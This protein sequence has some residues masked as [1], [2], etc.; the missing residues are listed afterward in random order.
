MN[1]KKLRPTQPPE[2]EQSAE[3][4]AWYSGNFNQ[5]DNTQEVMRLINE[6]SAQNGREPL[7]WEETLKIF[8]DDI[9]SRNL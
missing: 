5:A 6:Y 7:Q 2:K 8:F 3:L 9:I 1:R 4:K